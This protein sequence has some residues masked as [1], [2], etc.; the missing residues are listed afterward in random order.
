MRIRGILLPALIGLVCGAAAPL[1]PPPVFAPGT[2][3]DTIQGVSVADPWRALENGDDPQVRAWS[4]GQNA[5]TRAYLDALPGHAAI[6]ERIGRLVRAASPSFAALQARGDRVFALYNDPALQQPSLVILAASLD[7]AS[8]RALVDPNQLDP[9]GH[10]AIDWFVASPDGSR[11][12]VSL[13]RNGSEDGTLHIYDVSSGREIEPPIDRVQYPTAGGA[14]AWAADGGGFWYTRYPD[15]SAPEAERH[16]NQ[17]LYY[18]RLGAPFADRLVLGPANGLPRTAEIFLDG[19]RGAAALASVQLGDGNQWQHFVLRPDGSF[20]QIGRYED[21]VI[22]GALI[23]GDGTVFGVSR[24]G[25]PMGKVLRLDPPYAGGFAR[26]RA[27]VP[28]QADAAIINGGES[29]APLEIAG[30][31]LFVSRVAGGP[32]QLSVYDLRGGHGSVVR[33]PEVASVSDLAALPNGDVVYNVATYLDPPYYA[34]WDARTGQSRRTALA[35]TSPISFADAEV[36]RIFATSSDGTRVPI[37]VIRRRGTRLDG[38]NPA[39]LYGYGGYGINMTPGFAGSTV[40][41]WLD[42]GGVYAVANIRGGAEYGEHWHEQ[43]MLTRKQNVFDD[44]TAAARQLIAAGYT[45]SGRL[46]LRGGSNGGLLM[47]AMI[48]QHPELMRAV[49]S[50]V[51][52]YDMVRVELDPNGAFNVSEFGTVADP[53]QFRALY[54]YSPYHHVRTGTNYPALLLMTGANDGRVN[55]LHS[56]KFAAALQAA[57]ASDRPILL[58]T[59]QSAGHGRGTSLDERIGESADILSFLFDQLGMD[60]AAAVAAPARNGN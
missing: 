52:I 45:G 30:D 58:R 57:T 21:R 17:A 43:G 12:G 56:R 48:T 9:A 10:I 6:A 23:A 29:D 41:L 4:D 26:A 32:S 59:S 13:S 47:G 38:R 60:P 54:A 14:M 16:F 28:E 3:A 39:L 49:V 51:G 1:P 46:A 35:M 7:P 44:F 33:T 24:L 34:R 2:V 36:V 40:R 15:A 22:G 18:H 11:V 53:D 37:N 55:P 25:A 50:Q 31:R 20:L 27:I 19:G 42:A 8:R 5:R